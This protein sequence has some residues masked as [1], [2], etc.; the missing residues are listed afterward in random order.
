MPLPARY[1][2]GAAVLDHRSGQHCWTSQQWHPAPLLAVLAPPPAAPQAPD[3]IV[4]I[5]GVRLLDTT[6]PRAAG[7][8]DGLLRARDGRARSVFFVN[9]HTLNLAAAD[10]SYR[11]VLNAADY[12]FGD[13]TGVRWAARLQGIRLQDNV[14]GTDLMPDFFRA[15]AGP[16]RRCFL[17]GADEPTLRRAAAFI[18]NSL[19]GW[20]VAGCHHGYLADASV[21]AEALRQIGRAQPDV[22]LVGMGNPLQEQW[23]HRHRDR[24]EV[25]LAIGVGGLLNFWSQNVPRRG[26]AAAL[27]LRVALGPLPAA[28]QG[29]AVSGRQSLVP[30][31]DRAR[32][33]LAAGRD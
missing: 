4:S 26:L 9:A 10:S 17:L 2:L 29:P 25:P 14:N 12:V 20:T 21:N 33:V 11:A 7:L 28:A 24:L 3:R 30:R 22:L 8:L 16:G 13:G 15:A 19:G 27:R 32:V 1:P 23:I 31:A 18:E 6:R 5:L